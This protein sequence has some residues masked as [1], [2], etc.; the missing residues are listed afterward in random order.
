MLALAQL[1]AP[2]DC[3]HDNA[4]TLSLQSMPA[5]LRE[6]YR[7][8]LIAASLELNPSLAE[9]S[10]SQFPLI[11]VKQRLEEKIAGTMATADMRQLA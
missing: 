1:I 10:C 5:M 8:L 11:P 9:R 7:E 4:S 6:P 2:E 3:S